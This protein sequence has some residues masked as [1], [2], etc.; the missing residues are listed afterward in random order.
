MESKHRRILC[1]G[2]VTALLLSI[3]GTGVAAAQQVH[4][5]A[6]GL[7]LAGVAEEISTNEALKVPIRVIH[8]GYGFA[9]SG[10]EFHVLRM[11]IVRARHIRPIYIR[12]L[13]EENKSIEEIRAE[14]MGAGWTPFYRGHLRL[15][16]NHYLLVNISIGDQGE[17]RIVNADVRERG[18]DGETV[19]KISVTVMDYEGLRIGDGTLTMSEGEYS[20]EYR[21]L[22]D[23]LP[24]LRRV[25]RGTE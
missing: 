15:G 12:G 17:A 9:L 5:G 13:M 16:E 8:S 19:G 22:L 1:M 3:A 24:P 20:G 7:S 2:V 21:V 6:R 10:D 11:H 18:E 4:R 14:I 23:I 25:R